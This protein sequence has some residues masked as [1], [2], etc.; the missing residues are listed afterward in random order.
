MK[1]RGEGLLC[2]IVEELFY[3]IKKKINNDNKILYSILYPERKRDKEFIL[4][5]LIKDY[6]I[7]S[8]HTKIVG[9]FK[10]REK[11]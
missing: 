11:K 9:K 10:E 3:F 1:G 4:N 5:E 6:Q 2:D 8:E 7:I